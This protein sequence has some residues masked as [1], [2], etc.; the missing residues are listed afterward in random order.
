MKWYFVFLLLAL[1]GASC[2]KNWCMQ[3]GAPQKEKTNESHFIPSKYCLTYLS[4]N[5]GYKSDSVTICIKIF[6]R[7]IGKNVDTAL[8]SVVGE[9]TTTRKCIGS[10]MIYKVLPGKKK[11]LINSYQNWFGMT[12]EIDF[13]NNRG[14]VINFF[15]GSKFDL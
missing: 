15:L 4:V 7:V 3:Y 5:D 6:S 12:K 14:Y 9:G 8:V 10:E 11:L 2:N 1:S 13:K